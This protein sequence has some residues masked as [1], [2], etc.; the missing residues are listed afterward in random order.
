MSSERYKHCVVFLYAGGRVFVPMSMFPEVKHAKDVMIAR[1]EIIFGGVIKTF[2]TDEPTIVPI[3]S[4]I[5]WKIDDRRF[6][7]LKVTS[8]R[9]DEYAEEWLAEL[10]CDVSGVQ[11][12]ERV[13]TGLD[14]LA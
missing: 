14:L 7:K 4:A 9:V 10:L 1:L 2:T 11:P 8:V 3:N 12:S 13:I 5:R 6:T